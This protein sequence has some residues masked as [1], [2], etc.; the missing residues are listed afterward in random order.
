MHHK[1]YQHEKK[2]A[3][4]TFKGGKYGKL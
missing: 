3:R 1:K 2:P 4:M